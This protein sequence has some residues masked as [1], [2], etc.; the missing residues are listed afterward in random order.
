MCVDN[1]TSYSFQWPGILFSGNFLCFFFTAAL[2][3][4]QRDE[5]KLFQISIS[6]RLLSARLRASKVIIGRDTK[7][8]AWAT[9]TSPSIL[10]KGRDDL[11]PPSLR[12][13]INCEWRENCLI[14]SPSECKMPLRLAAYLIQLFRKLF[15]RTASELDREGTSERASVD[16]LNSQRAKFSASEFFMRGAANFA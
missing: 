5:G 12:P 7:R 13:L 3:G 11:C 4:N 15:H 16:T 8:V 1:V 6:Q 9:V 2:A 10:S 14:T